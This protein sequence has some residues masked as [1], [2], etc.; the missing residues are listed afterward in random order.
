MRIGK[1]FRMP[2]PNFIES[3]EGFSVEVLGQVGMIYTE[4]GKTLDI[5]SEVLAHSGIAMFASS[6]QVWNDGGPIDDVTRQQIIQNIRRAIEFLGDHL[7]I[8]DEGV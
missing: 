4:G 1:M 2:R 3:S 5:E 6:L 8:P 7:V